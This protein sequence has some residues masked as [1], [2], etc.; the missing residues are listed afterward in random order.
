MTREQDIEKAL[1]DLKIPCSVIGTA[2]APQIMRYQLQ[3][4][5]YPYASSRAT[6]R[7]IRVSEVRSRLPDIE[8]A[9]GVSGISLRQNGELWLEIP[10]DDPDPVYTEGLVYLAEK[11][12]V[13]VIIGTSVAGGD[14]VVD[15]ALPST[16]HVLVGGATGSG[17]STCINS[18]L[19]G[20]ILT[21]TPKQ[22]GICLAD[23]KYIELDRWLVEHL[24]Y[25][26]ANELTDIKV[27]L[28]AVVVEMDDRYMGQGG[29]DSEHIVVVIDEFA[30]LIIRDRDSIE[31]LIIR[32]AQK[33][34]A[35][36]IHLIIATQ[37]PSAD[38]VTGA[39]KANFPVRIAFAL[40][41]QVDSRVIIDANGAE[42]LRG[43]GDGLIKSG[44]KTLRFQGAIT[45]DIDAAIAGHLGDPRYALYEEE[46]V[47]TEADWEWPDDLL[48]EHGHSN[49]SGSNNED[50]IVA[51]A[52]VGLGL[53]AGF[54]TIFLGIFKG[55]FVF[56]E[57][58][59]DN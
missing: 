56:L 4:G 54:A 55:V 35:A 25:P 26:I 8:L 33:G 12:T 53:I 15:L 58:V 7:K 20:I 22:V 13:P 34:R 49:D 57:A 52:G 43:Y 59:F 31:D 50:V 36:G 18:I 1:L 2:T 41:S 16:P 39:I 44:L 29:I 24:V 27:M 28:E 32:I 23:P 51:V 9:I 14:V 5:N 42:R 45:R 38:I 21:K 47:F 37:R 3:P 30:D 40:P 6:T 48:E 19:A 11:A 10:R 17:K 46:Y